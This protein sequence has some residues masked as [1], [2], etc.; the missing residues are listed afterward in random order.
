MLTVIMESADLKPVTQC[1]VGD[2]PCLVA[3]TAVR[4]DMAA[5]WPER[6]P[7]QCYTLQMVSG[8]ALPILKDV[9]LT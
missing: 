7:N 2:K 4:P 6:L 1:W 8:E 3:V 9:F 5:G